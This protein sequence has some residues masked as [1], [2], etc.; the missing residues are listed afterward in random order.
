MK[1][2]WVLFLL[3]PVLWSCTEAPRNA[4]STP[5][6]QDTDGSVA[7]ADSG[8]VD[9]VGLRY[10]S[11]P[12]GLEELGGSL[13]DFVDEP[14][15]PEGEQHESHQPGAHAVD[16][17]EP[18]VDG[19]VLVNDFAPLRIDPAELAADGRDAARRLAASAGI[20]MPG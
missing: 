3:G 20:Q 9:Y 11:L 19:E 18:V 16:L 14:E 7:D 15:N 1:R 2:P 10:G 8:A 13:L 4:D 5:E 6:V 17:V 12:P